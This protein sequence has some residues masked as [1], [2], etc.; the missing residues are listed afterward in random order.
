[1]QNGY[2]VLC[3]IKIKNREYRVIID[4]GS[5][6]TLFDVKKIGCLFSNSI[7]KSDKIS[8]DFN[9]NL[10]DNKIFIIDEFFIGNIKIEN[11]ESKLTDFVKF[12]NNFVKNGLPKV[13]GII[14]NDILIKYN[15]IIDFGK[16][17]MVLSKN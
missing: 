15:S 9:G 14:G 5:T 3:R 6:E 13:D 1:M 10:I 11:F 7:Q 2:H 8:Y 17:E 4:T 12:N 16:K